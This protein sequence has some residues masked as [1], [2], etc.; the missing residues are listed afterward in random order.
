[1]VLMFITLTVDGGGLWWRFG[2]LLP[3]HCIEQLIGLFRWSGYN[4]CRTAL[5]WLVLLD[6]ASPR[7][8]DANLHGLRC[9]D[10]GTYGAKH[11]QDCRTCVEIR[12]RCCFC[13]YLHFIRQRNADQQTRNIKY[14]SD[15]VEAKILRPRP[16]PSRPRPDL[17]GQGHSS[18]D[19]R[20]SRLLSIRRFYDLV[21]K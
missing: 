15:L 18:G 11:F 8:R 16:Q 20:Q 19:Q 5:L 10:P 12:P 7:L 17:R 6:T 9:L 13:I 14:T 1:M 4:Q 21:R 2:R 3:V